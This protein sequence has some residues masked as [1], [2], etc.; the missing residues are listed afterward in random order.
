MGLACYYKR[1][2]KNYGKIA[3]PLTALLEKK[4]KKDAFGWNAV[5]QAPFEKLKSSMTSLPI[6]ADPDFSKQCI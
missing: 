3:Q 5:V 4:K 2:V 6:L 1:F